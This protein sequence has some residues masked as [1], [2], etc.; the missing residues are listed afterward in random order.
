MFLPTVEGAFK[1]TP[2]KL[3]PAKNGIANECGSR[4][5][6][7]DEIFF[8]FLFLKEKKGKKKGKKRRK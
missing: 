7:L 5:T 4:L 3:K 8:F 6:L 1:I 2:P